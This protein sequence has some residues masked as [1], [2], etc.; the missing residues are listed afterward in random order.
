MS[1]H[2]IPVTSPNPQA[3]SWAETSHRGHLPTVGQPPGVFLGSFSFLPSCSCSVAGCGELFHLLRRQQRPWKYSLGDTACIPLSWMEALSSG[4]SWAKTSS[5]HTAGARVGQKARLGFFIT[6]FKNSNELSGQ[7][8]TC[9]FKS[10]V[11]A[12]CTACLPGHAP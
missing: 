8:N 7:A 2:C 11:S 10:L 12:Q 9:L 6:L 4:P 1:V 3:L 5:G